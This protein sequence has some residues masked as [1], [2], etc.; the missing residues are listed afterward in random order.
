MTYVETARTRCCIETLNLQSHMMCQALYSHSKVS[1]V[2]LLFRTKSLGSTA[3]NLRESTLSLD[4]T[5]YPTVSMHIPANA[6]AEWLQQ[7][8]ES[9]R[10]PCS[11]TRTL[12]GHLRH[13]S[14]DHGLVDHFHRRPL[15]AVCGRVQRRRRRSRCVLGQS[16]S[17]RIKCCPTSNLTRAQRP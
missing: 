14:A 8:R 9:F 15:L 7:P 16:F 1:F 13:T 11:L 4:L 10:R 12:N 17:R 5:L 6:F 3:Y 2:Q